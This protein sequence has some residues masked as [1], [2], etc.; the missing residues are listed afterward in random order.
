MAKKG[1]KGPTPEQWARWRENEE[2]ARRLL[3]RIRAEEAA[4]AEA[5]AKGERQ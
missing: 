2:R 3:D 5:A 1:K 4:Q